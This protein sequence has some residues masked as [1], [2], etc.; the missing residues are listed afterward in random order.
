[1][2]G[3]PRGT[4]SCVIQFVLNEAAQEYVQGV[5]LKRVSEK[6][7]SWFV[8][9]NVIEIETAH[10]SSKLIVMENL[11]AVSLCSIQQY[12]L[13]FDIPDA[14]M[15]QLWYPNVN[16]RILDAYLPENDSE[17]ENPARGD[18]EV[19]EE[20]EPDQAVI[21]K[22]DSQ[23]L[24]AH[25]TKWNIV[26]SPDE[27]ELL[28]SLTDHQTTLNWDK[29]SINCASIVLFDERLLTAPDLRTPLHYFLLMFPTDFTFKMCQYTNMSVRD[30]NGSKKGPEINPKIFFKWQCC[31]C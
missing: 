26:H 12:G 1:M 8:R 23:F 3:G 22:E 5:V 29:N 16:T 13:L 6:S 11:I 2:Q 19:I 21:S 14:I 31:T 7:R 17:D 30:P 28:G 20:I 25:E 15:N 9:W 4:S 10:A 27:L 24:V 18:I